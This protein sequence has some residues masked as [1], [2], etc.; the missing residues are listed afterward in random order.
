MQSIDLPGVPPPASSAGGEPST[1]GLAPVLLCHGFT[2]TPASMAIW[3]QGLHAAGHRVCVP[4]LPGHGGS[5]QQLNRTRWMDWYTR[6]EQELLRLAAEP[7]GANGVVV[8]GLSLGGA[9]AL[10]L[11]QQHPDL[12]RAL[13]LVNPG[14]VLDDPRLVALPVL[15]WIVP[16]LSG[17]ASDIAKPGVVE[18][19][20][21]R[22]P[23]HALHSVVQFFRIV[24]RDLPKIT[25][26]TIVFRS[27]HDH[28]VPVRS[29]L[30]VIER[31]S[32]PTIQ[33]V[34]LVES[35][36]VA[37]LDYDAELIIERSEQFIASLSQPGPTASTQ[38]H[39]AGDAANG[40]FVP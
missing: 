18:E 25:A 15:R 22:T 14:V 8:G 5:A 30:H 35:F 13:L 39:V 31:I 40:E 33:D 11:A 28:V 24:E 20:T 37:T 23:L 38:P 7:G 19:A 16:S 27:L 29:P 36:H 2:S 10:R 21:P 1:S 6:L 26:P 3:A 34:P 4:R 9:L 17:L 32:S 12:V